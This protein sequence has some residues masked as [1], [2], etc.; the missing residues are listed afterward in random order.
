MGFFSEIAS[1]ARRSS[2]SGAP[3]QPAAPERPEQ[4][5]PPQEAPP[6]PAPAAPEPAPAPEQPS[7]PSAHT[8]PPPE[9]KLTVGDTAPAPDD[10]AARQAHEAAE[11]K[12]KAEFDAKQAEKKAARQAALDRIAAMNRADLLA[13]SVERVAADTE[14]LTRRNMK[15][16]V[17][18]HI[19][20]KCR[21]DAAFAMLV[22]DPAKSMVNCFQYINRKAQ[23]YAEQ[24]MK[25]NG[26]QR[27]GVYGLDVPDGLCFQWA[28]DY[29]KDENAKEDH[30]EDEKFVPKPYVPASTPR[31]TAKGKAAKKPTPAAKPKAAKPTNTDMEQISLM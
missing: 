26:I 18:E 3:P 22:V 8:P 16:A 10:T 31:K 1:E 11:A 20:A 23:E 13:A 5:V 29:F 14:R 9:V 17:A 30:N 24:E 12:R 21:E 15:E 19:Q 7:T 6:E 4:R 25:D 27:T 28:E 2:R